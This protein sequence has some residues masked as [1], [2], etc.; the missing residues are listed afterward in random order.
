M[1]FLEL[2]FLVFSHR[3]A[4]DVDCSFVYNFSPGIKIITY[5]CRWSN[6]Y[7]YVDC[8]IIK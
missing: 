1:I 7:T 2:L 6:D 8:Q 3:D 4:L 5:E